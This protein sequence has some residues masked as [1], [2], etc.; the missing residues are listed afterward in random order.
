MYANIDLHMIGYA[1]NAE[2]PAGHYV[3]RDCTSL[4]INRKSS[5]PS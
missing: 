2:G 5:P 4:P 3:K 1:R